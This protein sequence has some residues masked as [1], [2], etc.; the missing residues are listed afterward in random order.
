MIPG[1]DLV[2]LLAQSQHRKQNV[3]LKLTTKLTK[4]PER[5]QWRPSGVFI[6]NYEQV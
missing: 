3:V 1:L 4:T 6:I 2:H 5:R